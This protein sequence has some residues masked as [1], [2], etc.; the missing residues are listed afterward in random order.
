MG[1]AARE[2]D[3]NEETRALFSKLYGRK[4]SEQEAKEI[5]ENFLGLMEVLKDLNQNKRGYLMKN[6]SFLDL[7]GK[8]R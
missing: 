2:Q 4:I 6:R 1:E 3:F 7:D 5:K 8:I